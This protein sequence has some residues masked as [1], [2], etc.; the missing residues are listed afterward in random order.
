MLGYIAIGKGNKWRIYQV[1]SVGI[2]IYERS[3]KSGNGGGWRKE[4]HEGKTTVILL[5]SSVNLSTIT[6]IASLS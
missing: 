1:E 3:L 5:N 4:H 2:G 6:S